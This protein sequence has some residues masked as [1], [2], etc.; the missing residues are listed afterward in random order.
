[1]RFGVYFLIDGHD[2]ALPIDEKCPTFGHGAPFVNHTIRLGYR[3]RRIAQNR[4]IQSQL[5]GELCVIFSCVTT[6]SEIGN[7]EFTQRVATL[8]E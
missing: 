2:L 3:L 7:I 4:I 6:G 1:M 5:F 8:P